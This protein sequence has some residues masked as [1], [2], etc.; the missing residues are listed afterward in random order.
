MFPD[1]AGVHTV[2][3]E[4]IMTLLSHARSLCEQLVVVVVARGLYEVEGGVR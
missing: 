4:M 2:T 1:I 3:E